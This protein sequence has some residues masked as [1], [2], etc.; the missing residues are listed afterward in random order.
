M[1]LQGTIPQIKRQLEVVTSHSI[2]GTFD[3]CAR[4]F[5][6][7]H[8]IRQLPEG[9]TTGFAAEVG[10]ALHEATQAWAREYYFGDPDAAYETGLYAMMRY[11]P[12]ALETEALLAKKAG[13]TQR[14]IGNAVLL[15]EEIIENRF[16]QDWELVSVPGFGPAIE[17][18]WKIVHTA[19]GSAVTPDGL[20]LTFAT[21]GKIDFVMRHRTTKEIRVIDL[22]TTVK[23]EL[24]HR[25]SFRFSGQGPMY[26]FI[27]A[28]ALGFDWRVNGL[29]V[30]YFVANFPTTTEGP[31]VNLRTYAL[32]PDE[33]VDGLE[34]LH[35]RLGRMHRY[36][37]IGKWPRTAKGCESWHQPCPWLDVCAS[38]DLNYIKLW[39]AFEG[40]EVRERIYDPIWVFND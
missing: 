31:E 30:S 6:F 1:T 26:A 20:E 37:T 35:E 7:Q 36:A 39:F 25:A 34:I 21:Q 27:I 40:F 12:W 10:T 3:T 33:V 11:W 8:V 22:K 9:G 24:L 14:G 38:R 32:T 29:K 19:M 17:I 15:Y 4:K 28:A 2:N 13:I 18:P 16:W 5:E 23:D